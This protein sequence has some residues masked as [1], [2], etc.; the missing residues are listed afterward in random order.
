MERLLNYK[1]E[2]RELKNIIENPDYPKKNFLAPLS[3]SQEDS[4]RIKS[5]MYK[6]DIFLNSLSSVD[7]LYKKV[8]NY[9]LSPE[10]FNNPFY[11]I[12][13]LEDFNDN[14][15][16]ILNSLNNNVLVQI[17]TSGDIGPKEIEFFSKIKNENVYFYS[18]SLI[19]QDCMQYL[20]SKFNI[21][22]ESSPVLVIDKIDSKTVDL[23]KKCLLQYP[24]LRCKI[25]IKDLSSIKNLNMILPLVPDDEILIF[26]DDNLF[27]DKNPNNIRS[28][29]LQ[30]DFSMN[31]NTP[32][33]KKIKINYN[34]LEYKDLEEVFNLERYLE[35]VKSH[36]PSNASELD[37]V[38]YVSLFEANYFTYDYEVYEKIK[39]KEDVELINL[40]DFIISRRGVCRDYAAFTKYLLNS[41]NVECKVLETG[42][43][44]YYDHSVDEGHAFNLVK[45]SGKEY[46]LDN[47][48]L[49]ETL[50]LG[51]I[52]SLAESPYF[53]TSN[54]DF[55][56]DEYKSILDN[57]HC[58]TMDRNE[59]NQS[60]TR[61][62]NWNKNYVIHPQALKDLF[63]KHIMKKQMT[64]E[65]QIEDAIPGRRR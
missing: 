65:N 8:E 17:A 6:Q 25:E 49:V 1:V 46:F 7:E 28:I 15:I 48:W 44:F 3:I 57:Y 47:T 37:I 63:R 2:L 30:Q 52:H 21:D 13:S 29:I 56:H 34:G 24:N 16:N 59:I 36:I 55:Q 39:A 62:L 50:Q 14:T 58:E 35:I 53:L 10:L 54:A 22:P 31:L 27:S 23:I 19:N 4:F 51:Q 38:T 32:K 64:V 11:L 5:I 18:R 33:N 12:V 45:I 43:E 60:T 42:S 26:L 40:T 9:E 20:I 41:L 61:V